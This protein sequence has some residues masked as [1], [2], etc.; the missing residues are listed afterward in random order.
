MTSTARWMLAA[1]CGATML[2]VGLTA[3]RTQA[4]GDL[5]F[6][7]TPNPQAGEKPALFVTPARPVKELYV[8]CT[9]GGQDHEWTRTGVAAGKQ[10]NFAWPRDTRHTHADCFVRATFADGYVSEQQLPIDYSFGGA[11]SVDLSRAEA[12]L[13]EHT[14]TVA[15]SEHVDTAE[16]VAYGAH[17]TL[18]DK[19][20]IQVD[21]GPGD[22]TLPWVGDP[23][24]VVLLEVKVENSNAWAGFEFSP[25]FL[26]IPHDDVLFE[27][28]SDVIDP[29]QEHKLERTLK[30]LNEVIDKYGEIV[31]VKLYIAGCTDTVGDAGGNRELSRR[32]AKAIAKWLRAHGYSHPIYYHGFGE[33]LLAV[34]TGDNVDEVRNRRALYMVGASAPGK[35]SGI[36]GVKW[37][38]L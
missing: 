6:G 12:D 33:S 37:T 29:D 2:T 16:I 25:W 21:S 13:K 1:L 23:G 31:P 4:G 27:S 19:R 35:G 32:R 15:V 26:D 38:A 22:I 10:Q 24:E 20:V 9:V 7:Y 8:S 5:D 30:D 11:L 36:P 17:K 18:L 34:P 28:N 3:S 14:L